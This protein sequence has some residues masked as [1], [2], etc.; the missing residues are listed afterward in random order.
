MEVFGEKQ[1]ALKEKPQA[2]HLSDAQQKLTVEYMAAAGEIQN[3]YI[4]GDERSFTIIAFPVPEI[5]KDFAAIFDEVI[6]INTLDYGLYQR[7]Q[8]TSSIPWIRGN[9]Y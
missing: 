9:M 4:K 1:C 6:R 7:M 3:R 8:Q 5:G 2:I